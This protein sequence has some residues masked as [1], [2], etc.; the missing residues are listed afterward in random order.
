MATPKARLA[1]VL[2]VLAVLVFFGGRAAGWWGGSG[3]TATK[4]YGNVEVREVELGFRVGGR[5]AEVMVDEGD[6]VVPGQTLARLDTQP[7]LDR[8]AG[9]DAKVAAASA[10]VSKDAAGNRPQEVRQAQSA[11]VD[12]EAR[13]SE[14]RRLN[15]RRRALSERGFIAKAELQD[16]QSAVAAASA[17]VEAARAALSLA[18]EGTRSED[19]IATRAD[20][21]QMAAERRSIQ[22]DLSD[23]V[24]KAPSAGQVLT[25]VREAGAIVQPGEIVYTVA[26]TQPVRVRAYVAEPILPQVRPGMR[27]T[28]HVDGRAKGWPATIGYISPVAEFT[29]RTVQTE[30]QRADLVYRLRLIVDDPKNELRQGQ[31]V[32]VTLPSATGG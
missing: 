18:Q 27:V 6:K 8:L 26:L 31:P 25:R 32:T 13:L 16:S 28:V 22:T 14:A 9:A 4:I 24:L 23:A 30:D 7:I 10:M 2:A 12:A 1:I 11:V 17:R 19:R 3:E 20:A 5:I 15:Q 29:P 21:A